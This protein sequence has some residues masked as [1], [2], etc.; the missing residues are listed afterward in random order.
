MSEHVSDV[1]SAGGQSPRRRQKRDASQISDIMRQVHGRDT[2]PEVRLRQ[3]LLARGLPHSVASEALPG[4]PD[5]VFPTERVAVFVDGDYWHGNQWRRRGKLALEEQFEATAAES[6]VYWLRKIRRNM[7]RDCQATSALLDAGWLVLRLWESQITQDVERCAQV[8]ADSVES[9]RRDEPAQ[10]DRIAALRGRLSQMTCAEFF[11][12]IGLMRLGLERQG[13]HVTFANDIDVRKHAMY[14]AHFGD[15]SAAHFA[16]GDVHAL[17]V[18]A[19]PSVTL[20]TASFPCND[21]SLAGGREGLAGKHSSAFW[22]FI[23]VL[24]ELGDRRP[25]LVLLEN[26]PG[27]LTA[28]DGEDFARALSALDSLGYAVDAFQLDAARFTPQSRRRVFVIGVQASLVEETPAEAVGLVASETRPQALVDAIAANKGLR[29]CVRRLP[30]PPLRTHSLT[31]ILED[32][33]DEDAAWWSADRATYLLNQMSPRHRALAQQ[34]IEAPEVSYGTIFRR[35]RKGRSMAELR[36]DGMAGCLRTPRG[37]SGRQILF[38]AGYGCYQA[39]LLTA[40]EAARLMGAGEFTI[41]GSLN[42]ALF[43]FGDAVCAD[44]I[45]WIATYYLNPLVNELIHGAPL[46]VGG[47][48]ETIS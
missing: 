13:W 3:A 44:A 43:G 12:G 42:D 33:P 34:M 14:T 29:W 28:Q 27:F 1:A 21:L 26:V 41:S 8:I 32:L 6:R 25:P 45:E 20:A 40:R 11:A 39:R 10:P 16:L 48:C 19:A 7:R 36:A 18:A 46:R 17:P 47:E 24:T 23:R 5:I 31:D 22:G 38:K 37:G 35:M 2:T 30:T 15:D 9:R 4:K